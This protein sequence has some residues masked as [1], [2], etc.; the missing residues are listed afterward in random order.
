MQVLRQL[1][2]SHDSL[3]LWHLGQH[4]SALSLCVACIAGN[5]PVGAF[6]DPDA[7]YTS[8]EEDYFS[9]E[10]DG[11]AEDHSMDLPVGPYPRR[12]DPAGNFPAISNLIHIAERRVRHPA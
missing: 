1:A 11:M 7:M 6:D 12:P 10:E 3:L 5:S 4:K 8:E 9:E 2:N